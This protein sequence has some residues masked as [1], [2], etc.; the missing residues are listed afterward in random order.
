MENNFPENY[1]DD[2]TV[3]NDKAGIPVEL[4]ILEQ[5]KEWLES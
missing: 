2:H 4:N 1:I 5:T 3:H